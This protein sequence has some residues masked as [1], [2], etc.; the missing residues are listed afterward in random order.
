MDFNEN[1]EKIWLEDEAG[2]VTA[3]VEFEDRELLESL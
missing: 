3:Y 2:R 1:A